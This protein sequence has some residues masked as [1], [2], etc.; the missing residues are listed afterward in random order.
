MPFG[1]KNAPGVFQRFMDKILHT[2]IMSGWLRVYIDDII[3]YSMNFDEY[4]KHITVVLQNWK[5]D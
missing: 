5:K 3:I 4:L 2:E 1:L